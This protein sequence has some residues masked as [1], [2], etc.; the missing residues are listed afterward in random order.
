[1]PGPTGH[2]S[3]NRADGAQDDEEGG[4]VPSDG[5]E[6]SGLPNCPETGNLEKEGRQEKD[7]QRQEQEARGYEQGEIGLHTRQRSSEEYPAYHR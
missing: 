5:Q 4:R 6:K 1:M 2:V 7:L 3:R